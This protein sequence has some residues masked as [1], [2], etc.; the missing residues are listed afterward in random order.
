[1]IDGFQGEYRFLS[2]FYISPI[3]HMNVKY[4]SVE[5]AY[6]ACKS[7]D[8][9]IRRYIASLDSPGKAKRYGKKV[10]LRKDWEVV[11]RD[12][13]Y[14][15]LRIKFSKIPLAGWLRETGDQKLVEGN[16]WHDNYWGVC[17]CMQCRH[18]KGEN[19][20][21]KLLMQIREEIQK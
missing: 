10:R 19:Q 20:L 4:P 2:N 18:I 5:H 6:Q 11:K 12:I 9:G 21:G 13:M 8:T 17:H 3:I 16:Y 1:M 7:M 15:L 14:K